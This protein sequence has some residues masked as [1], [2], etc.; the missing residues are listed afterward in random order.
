M[1]RPAS[2]NEQIEAART[3]LR[4][5]KTVEQLR[6][7]Q[8][9][10]LP[11]EL[12]LSLEQTAQAIGRSVSATCAMRTR[13]VQVQTGRRKAPRRKSELRNRATVGLEREGRILDEV[14]KGA[15]DGAVLVIPGL[16]SAL[17]GRLGRPVA[18][19]TVYRMLARHGWRKLAPD[20]RH[21]QGDPAAG[22]DWK[23]NS[24]AR[25]VKK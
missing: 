6:Q 24:P 7:A 14:L 23:K 25:W 9:V 17:E 1:A 22:E 3:L 15:T 8:A 4:E 20:T 2:G 12:G 13:F 5:A 18:L 21:P 10:L 16:K 19:S 11:L